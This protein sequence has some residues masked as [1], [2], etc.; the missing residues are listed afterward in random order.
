VH[1]NIHVM[2]C[3]NPEWAEKTAL[4]IMKRVYKLYGTN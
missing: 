3:G 2:F 1:H 4:S